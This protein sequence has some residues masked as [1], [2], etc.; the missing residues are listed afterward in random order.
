[1]SGAL[2][3][4]FI[5]INIFFSVARNTFA[6]VLI[7]LMSMGT[8]IM[9]TPNAHKVKPKLIA[10]SIL[11]FASNLAYLIAIYLNK[12]QPLSPTI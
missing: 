11:Y 8:G 9:A 6:R 4:S 7:L 2:E 3:F 10:L 12:T 1:M 5:F